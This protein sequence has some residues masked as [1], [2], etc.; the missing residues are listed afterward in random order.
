MPRVPPVLAPLS[1]IP[2][3]SLRI[4]SSKRHIVCN[5]HKI[6]DLYPL[7]LPRAPVS[8]VAIGL[9]CAGVCPCSSSCT[10]ATAESR[11]TR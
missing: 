2:A 4:C 8:D 7:P 11:L 6:H 1:S 5:T 10:C 9:T 3:G